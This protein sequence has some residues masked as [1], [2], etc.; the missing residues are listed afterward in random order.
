MQELT[1]EDVKK[2][3]RQAYLDRR[4]TA[5]GP[6]GLRECFYSLGDRCCAIGAAFTPET[7]KLLMEVDQ[8]EECGVTA[9]S[10]DIVEFHAIS[11]VLAIQEA[12]DAWCDVEL[13]ELRLKYERRF[14]DLIETPCLDTSKET[15]E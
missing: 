4:L 15:L 1:L 2:A 7:I 10:H 13:P 11:S 3:A 5:Q 14:C 9:I 8:N 6:V 12:H